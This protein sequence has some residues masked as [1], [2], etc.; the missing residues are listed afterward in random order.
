MLFLCK[1]QLQYC[2]VQGSYVP[3][4]SRVMVRANASIPYVMRIIDFTRF[5]FFVTIGSTL[6][7]G[8]LDCWPRLPAVV[9]RCSPVWHRCPHPTSNRPCR[10]HNLILFLFTIGLIFSIVRCASW[11]PCHM[12]WSRRKKYH[13]T[14]HPYSEAF[15]FSKSRIVFQIN[16]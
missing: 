4:C 8:G 9:N 6:R 16:V 13:K 12:R 5:S 2:T 7:Y 1:I 14:L 3:K 11:L 15:L 10:T